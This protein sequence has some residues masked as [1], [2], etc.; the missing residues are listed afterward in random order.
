MTGRADVSSMYGSQGKWRGDGAVLPAA[1][2]LR[3]WVSDEVDE[4]KQIYSG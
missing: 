2:L 3:G 1:S 4:K